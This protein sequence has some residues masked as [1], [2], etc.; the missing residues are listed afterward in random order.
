MPRA[1]VRLS[2]LIGLLVACG[3]AW[4][5]PV[6]VASRDLRIGHPLTAD[7]V[8]TVDLPDGAVPPA[9]MRELKSVIGRVPN[10]PFYAGDFLREERLAPPGAVEGVDAVIPFTHVRA[11]LPAVPVSDLYRV[12]QH[13]DVLWTRP[14]VS[15]RLLQDVPIV[16]V[17]NTAGRVRTT[18]GSVAA[19]LVFALTPAQAFVVEYAKAEGALTY[20]VRDP[21]DATITDEHRCPKA[22]ARA[23]EEALILPVGQSI[24]LELE[25]IVPTGISIANGSLV[26]LHGMGEPGWVHLV[27]RTAGVTTLS[28]DLRPNGPH[29]VYDLRVIDE[30]AEPLDPRDAP[31]NWFFVR[32]DEAVL[33][34]FPTEP[35]YIRAA[36]DLVRVD[37]LGRGRYLLVGRRIGRT[38]LLVRLPGE[39]ESTLY[40]VDVISDHR[41]ADRLWLAPGGKVTVPVDRPVTAVTLLDP[42]IAQAKASATAVKL[43]GLEAGKTRMILFFEGDSEGR[44]YDVEVDPAAPR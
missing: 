29:L 35:A 30:L 16:G 19:A 15:C 20:A 26:G 28:V 14:T 37:R 4:A 11:D 36:S 23:V 2:A 33:A 5:S 34:T 41:D 10:A 1:H 32:D 8:G 24:V 7:D 39:P 21:G 25:G 6:V 9:A 3:S 27:G 38:D 12:G 44:A 43:K 42:G 31:A 13:V 18:A 22:D 17:Q 40:G